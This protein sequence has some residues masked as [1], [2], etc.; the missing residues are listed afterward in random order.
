MARAIGAIWLRSDLPRADLH[1][2]STID[3][4]PPFDYFRWQLI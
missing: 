2:N 4:E 3:A 1:Q